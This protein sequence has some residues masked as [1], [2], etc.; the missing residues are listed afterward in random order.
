MESP[1]KGG[2]VK[3]YIVAND[4]E[5]EFLDKI[6]SK[7]FYFSK[8]TQPLTVS[9]VRL[10]YTVKEKGGKT[11]P[12]TLWFKKS[13]NLKSKNSQDYV[14]KTSTKLYVHEFSLRAQLNGPYMYLAR[15]KISCSLPGEVGDLWRQ[16]IVGKDPKFYLGHFHSF[17]LSWQYHEVS[18]TITLWF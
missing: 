16:K 11:I 10:L 9:R 17:G 8:L 2:E 1:M 5:A 4:S 12:P 18:C 15:R 3:K 7:D 14:Q 13:I 6:Q